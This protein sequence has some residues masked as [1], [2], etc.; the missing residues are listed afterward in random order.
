MN[1][2]KNIII[3]NDFV[4]YNTKAL[5][6][7]KVKLPSYVMQ[8]VIEGNKR[9]LIRLNG[10]DLIIYTTEQ[11]KKNLITVE[12]KVYDGFFK[13]EKIQYNLAQIKI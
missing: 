3:R 6:D 8:D 9:I 7:N 5:F 2:D 12:A 4:I 1:K 11:L 13:K 10:K